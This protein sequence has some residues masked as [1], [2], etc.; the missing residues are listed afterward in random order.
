MAQVSAIKNTSFPSN[1]KYFLVKER[2]ARED[3][4]NN[5]GSFASMFQSSQATLGHEYDITCQWEALRELILLQWPRLSRQEVDAAGPSRS[6][7][8]MLVSARYGVE[9][10]LIKNY[11]MNLERNLPLM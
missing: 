6:Y 7:L 10:R 1:S 4:G 9:S 8:A 3:K 11:L 2:N 5:G